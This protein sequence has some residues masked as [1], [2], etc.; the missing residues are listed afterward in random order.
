MNLAS[1]APHLQVGNGE[2]Q[3]IL[4]EVTLANQGD[5]LSDQHI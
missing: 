2:T 4:L 1:Q 3:Q 5:N